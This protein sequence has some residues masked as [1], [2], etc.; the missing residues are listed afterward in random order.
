MTLDRTHILLG[1]GVVLLALFGVYAIEARI[2]DKAESRAELAAAHAADLEKANAT[3]QAQT[4]AQ[5]AALQTQLLQREASEGKLATQSG[6]YTAPQVAQQVAAI[7]KIPEA[8]VTATADSVTF[9]LPLA[10]TAL[11][12]MQ[13]VPLLTQDKND[14]TKS[15]ELEKASHASDVQTCKVEVKAAQAETSAAKAR[16]KKSWLKGFFVGVVAGFIGRAAL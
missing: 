16:A 6:S 15:L 12:D 14:L 7:A 5:I 9:P 11:T 13:L 1:L 10:Q 8:S 3:F 2:A 4:T